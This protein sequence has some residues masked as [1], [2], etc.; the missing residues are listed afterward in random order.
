M[1]NTISF[2][3]NYI[4][5]AN[6]LQRTP[7]NEFKNKKVSFVKLNPDSISDKATISILDHNWKQRK[8]FANEILD[9]MVD[10]TDFYNHAGKEFFAITQQ[11][12]TFNHLN[13]EKILGVAEVINGTNS[14]VKLKYIQVDPRQTRNCESATFKHVGSALL[15]S[16]KAY[17]PLKN[18][19]LESVEKAENFYLANGFK[20]IFEKHFIFKR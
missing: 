5:S 15:D 2:K 10:C 8:T 17:F 19:I 18:I 3:A 7:D 11:K 14:N 13:P 4:S 16:I 6:V 20:P 12:D 1:H 9:D